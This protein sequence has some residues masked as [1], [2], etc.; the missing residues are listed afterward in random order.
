V[1]T[2][3]ALALAQ[4][5][6]KLS[7]L[8]EH[9]E[10]SHLTGGTASASASASASG[11]CSGS[12]SGSCPASE[13]VKSDRSG[14]RSRK[15]ALT[16][17]VGGAEGAVRMRREQVSVLEELLSAATAAAAA[18]AAAALKP[19]HPTHTHT[20][21]HSKSDSGSGQCPTCGQSIQWSSQ[22][23]LASLERRLAVERCLLEVCAN[24]YLN[25][26]NTSTAVLFVCMSH[27]SLFPQPL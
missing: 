6:A 10:E 13:A 4:L 7:L 21:T 19:S 27:L 2:D 16:G 24:L 3:R 25:C 15:D 26:S 12:G 5:A 8:D 18:A 22:E 14:L 11:S 9:L 23:D 17:D 20:H 1:A